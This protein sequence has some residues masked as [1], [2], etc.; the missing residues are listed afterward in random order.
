MSFIHRGSIRFVSALCVA[1]TSVSCDKQPPANPQKIESD[2]ADASGKTGDDKVRPPEPDSESPSDPIGESPGLEAAADGV[3]TIDLRDVPDSLRERIEKMQAA[4]REAPNNTKRLESLAA[5]YASIN[6]PG[7]AAACFDRAAEIIPA[8]FKF[9]YLGGLLHLQ[10]GNATAARRAFERAAGIDPNYAAVHVNLGLLAID[11]DT[12]AAQEQFEQATK[13]DPSDEIA[14]WGLGRCAQKQKKHAEAITCFRRALDI[15]PNY[16][17]AQSGA[18]ESYRAVGDDD[19]AKRVLANHEKSINASID[20]DPVLMAFSRLSKS[21]EELVDMAMRQAEA[22]NRRRA[23]Q[24]LGAMTLLGRDGFTVRR[25]LGILFLDQGETSLSIDEFTK[26]LNFN[27]DSA[28]V[29]SLIANAYTEL[30]QQDQAQTHLERAQALAPEDPN[31]LSVIATLKLAQGNAAE[32]EKIFKQAI[33][34]APNNPNVLYRASKASIV[35]NDLDEA[36]RRLSQC[37]AL[38][39]DYPAAL[40]A[41]GLIELQAGKRDDAQTLWRKIVDSGAAFPDAYLGLAVFSSQASD[42]TNAAEFLRKG[43]AKSPQSAALANAL[44]WTLATTP[45]DELR[46]PKQAVKLS[47]YACRLTE[48]S[49]HEFLDTLSVSLAA[50]GAFEPAKKALEEAIRIAEAAGA[51]P[52]QIDQYSKRLALFKENKP[53]VRPAE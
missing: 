38:A 16:R 7:A 14:W 24:A 23:I 10:S 6:A 12:T 33:E 29:H 45:N 40:Y 28:E 43:L 27:P 41:L 31:V 36:R 46:D 4:C 13:L 52:E 42:D 51:R 32:A 20:N 39:P 50:D 49:N 1:L 37:I 25:A 11:E 15:L 53:F 47:D 26:A 5:A 44:A 21:D 3:P 2:G 17:D 8:N 35:L 22:G 34:K 30:G 48:H 18:A 9:H 19:A